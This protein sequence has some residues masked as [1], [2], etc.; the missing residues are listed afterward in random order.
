MCRRYPPDESCAFFP[1]GPNFSSAVRV[2][3]HG[4]VSAYAI[5]VTATA[6][7][8]I[9]LSLTFVYAGSVARMYL[10]QPTTLSEARG[11]L[12]STIGAYRINQD[13]FE[14]GLRFFRQDQL[15]EARDA[16]AQADPARQDATVQFY[17]A[18]TYLRQG[19]GRVY[20][21]DELY[22][23]GLDTLEHAR[24]LAPGRA[25]AVDDANLTLRTAEE[26]EAEFLRGLTR[27]ASDFNPARL[28]RERP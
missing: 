8:V 14:A 9:G 2:G 18:Y 25:I 4:P 23:K 13:R 27:D 11:T 7:R 15:A 21:D 6:L 1:V 22:K 26:L 17:V 12:T 3:R 20:S 16:F 28:L 24:R 19:W 5:S 10:R